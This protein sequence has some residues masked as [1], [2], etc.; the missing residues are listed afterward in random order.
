[1]HGNVIDAMVAGDSVVL[2][3]DAESRTF[4]NVLDVA[5]ATLRLKK[6]VKI[7][8]QLTYAEL[9]PAGL[10]YISRPD[11]ATN[12]EVDRKSTRLNSSHSQISYAVFCLKKKKKIAILRYHRIV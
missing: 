3:V 8:G 7:K 1:M 9:T 4:V 11:P 2:A 5:T 6:D 10:L 12:A